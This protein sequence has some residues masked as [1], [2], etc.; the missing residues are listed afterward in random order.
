[1]TY[2]QTSGAQATFT[3]IT[4]TDTTD[5]GTPGTNGAVSFSKSQAKNTV[6]P[7]FPN[8]GVTLLLIPKTTTD[9]ITYTATRNDG[10][11]V[12]CTITPATTVYGS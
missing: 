6:T 4:N 11:Q 7:A 8:P 5:W 12:S 2:T 9:T 3:L 1:M 10:K